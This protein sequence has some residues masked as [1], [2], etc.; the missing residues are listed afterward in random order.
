MAAAALRLDHL[1][2]ARGALRLYRA[3][4]RS[5]PRGAL[6]EEALLGVADA[7]HRLADGA[8][9]DTLASFLERFPDSPEASRARARLA[10]LRP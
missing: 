3:A 2:D 8:E 10:K 1:S 6:S 5:R 4:L 7:Q 9:A